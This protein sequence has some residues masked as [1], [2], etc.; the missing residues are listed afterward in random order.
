MTIKVNTKAFILEKK[1]CIGGPK[2]KTD[3][4]CY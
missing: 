4:T 2:G 1:K 3:E